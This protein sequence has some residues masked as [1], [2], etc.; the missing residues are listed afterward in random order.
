[1]T[2]SL[3]ASR[4]SSS[5]PTI[6][7][8]ERGPAGPPELLS[9][10][11]ADETGRLKALAILVIGA[12]G[13]FALWTPLGLPSELLRGLIAQPTNICRGGFEAF[14]DAG[15]PKMYFCSAGVGILTMAGPILLMV[16]AFV[17]RKTLTAFVRRFAAYLPREAQFM[18]A[19]LLATLLFA[20]SWSG[21]HFATGAT[22][23][24][25][26]QRFFPAAIGLFTFAVQRWGGDVQRRL[27]PF[28]DLRDRYPTRLRIAAA[29][30][31][32]LVLSLLIT[33]ETRVS[34]TAFKEQLVVL[35][36]LVSGF[37]AL[38]PRSGDVLSGVAGQV[39]A[40]RPA[41]P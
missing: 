35:V 3:R 18:V 33:S 30:V 39:A 23:G 17:F 12:A 14:A 7:A 25:I 32:P 21:S 20:M 29:V 19:P 28:F 31:V 9:R 10:V 4:A 11:S 1:M 27:T 15:T 26:P 36:G 5:R 6:P 13:S 24:I 41:R 37:L 2:S 34:N 38:A 40:L 16:G 8:T 22:M